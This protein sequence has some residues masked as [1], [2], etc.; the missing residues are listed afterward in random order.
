MIVLVTGRKSQR[1]FLILQCAGSYDATPQAKPLYHVT[2][3]L[4]KVLGK[5]PGRSHLQEG[6]LGF[7]LAAALLGLVEKGCWRETVLK[8]SNNGS[9]P[10]GAHRSY[11]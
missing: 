6:W 1:S 8:E 4:S 10:S 2:Q 3:A 9:R 11:C 7:P 5:V